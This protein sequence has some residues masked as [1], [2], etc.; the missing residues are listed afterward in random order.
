VCTKQ[1][2]IAEIARQHRK[3][4]LTALNHYLD[5]PWLEEAYQRVRQDSAPGIDGQTVAEYGQA[6]VSNLCHLLHQAKSGSYEAPPVKRVHIPKGDGKETRPIGMPTTGDKVLQ[7]A[8]VM[9]LEPIYEEEFYPFS[10]GFRPGRSAHQALD[11]FWRQASRTGIQWVLEVDIRKYFDSVSRPKL[12]ELVG[13]R[14]GDGTILRLISKWLH[15]GVM[16]KGRLHYPEAGT[17]QGGVISPLLSNIYLHEV[18]DRWFAEVV[19]ERMRGRALAVRYADDMVLGFTHRRDAEKVYRVLFKRFEKYGLSL[20]PEK[21]R[22]V[23]FGRP[24]Q[25]GPE[26]PPPPP[27]TFDFLGFT[28]YWG[29]SRE[30]KWVLK[31]K[32]AAKRRS[33]TLKALNLWCRDHRHEGLLAQFQTLASKLEGHYAYYGITGNGRG[34]NQVYEATKKLWHKWLNRRSNA[35]RGMT[36]QR[37]QQVSQQWLV[38]PQPHIVHSIYKAKP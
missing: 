4:R 29:K 2:R 9:L 38:L 15:A 8:A 3:E 26:G 10:Y 20:H 30:G 19:Q 11:A 16:E 36:W 17:P 6:L 28:H 14:I 37:F 34:L 22:L 12:M 33:R 7:R 18:F 23:P 21:T 35:P 13:Q 32:T 25:P 31:R 1:Q 5:I 24:G 27:G